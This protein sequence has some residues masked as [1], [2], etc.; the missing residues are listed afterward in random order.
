MDLDKVE[1][2]CEKWIMFPD[3]LLL[4]A[5]DVCSCNEAS[6]AYCFLGPT[7]SSAH[8]AQSV[9]HTGHGQNTTAWNTLCLFPSE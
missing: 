2:K 6:V 5:E 8:S 4:P 3:I 1:L 9:A 7:A